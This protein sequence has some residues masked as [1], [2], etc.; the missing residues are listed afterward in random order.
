MQSLIRSLASTRENPADANLDGTAFHRFL[1]DQHN[2]L[3]DPRRNYLNH[4]NSLPLKLIF[5][6]IAN[7][8]A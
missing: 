2:Y 8:R 1:F 7:S 4:I 5:Y 6:Y 3:V